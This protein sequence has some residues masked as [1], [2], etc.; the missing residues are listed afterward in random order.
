MKKLIFIIVMLVPAVIQA[1]QLPLTESY[2]IDPF[3]L[4]SAYAGVHNTNT[5][6]INY[7]SDWTGISGGPKTFRLSYHQQLKMLP[8]VSVGVKILADQTDIFHQN[9]MLTSYAYSF[10]VGENQSVNFGLS[11]GFYRNSIRFDKYYNS[12]DNQVDPALTMGSEKS[13]IKFMTDYGALYRWK[14]LEAG[15]VFMNVTFGG[16]SYP[17]ATETANKPLANYLFHVCYKYRFNDTWSIKP[18]T[19]IRAGKDIPSQLEL[20]AQAFYKEK[21]WASLLYRGK[22]IW[23]AGIGGE[24]FTG[25]LLAYSYNAGY[26]IEISAFQNHEISLGINFENLY[27]SVIK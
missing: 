26:N 24:I 10:K 6:L 21:Y 4:S 20:A 5:L 12:P 3:V 22:G 18:F 13:K 11:F 2:L 16:S 25:V 27:K 7:R 23:S 9:Y 14:E 1:Q 17:N 15:F 19:I 8:H